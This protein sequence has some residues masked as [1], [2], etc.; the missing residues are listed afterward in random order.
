MLL[1]YLKSSFRSQDIYYVTAWLTN[2]H[3][4]NIEIWSVNRTREMFFFRNHAEN[5]A[6][7][8]VPVCLFFFFKKRALYKVKASG[9]QLGSTIFRQ[10]S[11]QHRA[12]TNCITLQATDPEIYSILIFQKRV[13]EEFLHHILLMIFSTKMFLML[14]SINSPN[15]IV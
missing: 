5:K 6:G 14:Y 10:H 7:R 8:L 12:K 9:L 2:N 3:N 13:W 4:T 15:L 1:F 11:N